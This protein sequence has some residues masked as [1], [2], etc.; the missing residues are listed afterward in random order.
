LKSAE[1]SSESSDVHQKTKEGKK[2]AIV[3]RIIKATVE[4]GLIKLSDENTALKN[5]RYVPCWE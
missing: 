4:A 1:K 5:R 2:M 3:S